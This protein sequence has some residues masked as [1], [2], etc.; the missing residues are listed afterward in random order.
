[1]LVFAHLFLNI[2]IKSSKLHFQSWKKFPSMISLFFC[3]MTAEVL[4]NNCAKG[5]KIPFIY[6]RHL[7]VS[8]FKA[9]QMSFLLLFTSIFRLTRPIGLA[10]EMY[11]M[12]RLLNF[13]ETRT[14]L[15]QQ[16]I[17][18]KVGL[19]TC[20]TQK[21]SVSKSWTIITLVKEMK[22]SSIIIQK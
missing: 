16:K 12:K 3:K 19:Y 14:L 22:K 10:V 8:W 7:K 18:E 20:N 21:V 17:T 1:M 9:Y 4:R 13:L 2:S 11:R 6:F 5:L 15:I